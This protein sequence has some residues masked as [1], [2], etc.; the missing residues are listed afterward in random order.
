VAINDILQAHLLQWYRSAHP[1]Q[2]YLHKSD[3]PDTKDYL[4]MLPRL[5]STAFFLPL[6]AALSQPSTTTQVDIPMYINHIDFAEIL[7]YQSDDVFPASLVCADSTATTVVLTCDSDCGADSKATITAGPSTYHVDVQLT[8]TRDPVEFT[9]LSLTQDCQISDSL[10]CNYWAVETYSPGKGSTSTLIDT[11]TAVNMHN[12]SMEPVLITAGLEKLNS[13]AC[14]PASTTA[15][16]PTPTVP[17]QASHTSN[18]AIR[19]YGTGAI[20]AAVGVAALE[21]F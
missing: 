11:S 21:I 10:A 3:F 14:V 4:K 18:A 2:H 7:Q 17:A 13:P 6:A 12:V 9:I 1:I 15:T 20:I 19:E 5:A 8:R 16:G